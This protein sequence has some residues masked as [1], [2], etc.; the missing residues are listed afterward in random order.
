ML[1]LLLESYFVSNIRPAVYNRDRVY[2]TEESRPLSTETTKQ[3]EPTVT[4]PASQSMLEWGE[5]GR[6]TSLAKASFAPSPIA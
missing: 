3:D 2:L 4:H 5:G 6:E 1:G